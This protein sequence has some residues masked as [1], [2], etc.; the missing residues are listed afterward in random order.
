VAS[1]KLAS[2]GVNCRAVSPVQQALRNWTLAHWCSV[3]LLQKISAQK[4]T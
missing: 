4:E 3:M 2:F 1:E